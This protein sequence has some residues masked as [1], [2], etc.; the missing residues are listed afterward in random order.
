MKI[1]VLLENTCGREGCTA[2]HGL[3]FY[4]ETETHRLL[5]D[6]GPDDT[7]LDNAQVLGIDLQ[8]I[9]MVII[10]HGHYDHAGGVL[11]FAKVNPQVEIIMQESAVL[12]HYNGSRYIGIDPEIANLSQ[13]KLISGNKRIDD[14]LFL[15]SGVTG[16]RDFPAG[17][18]TMRT[19][20]DGRSIPDDFSHEQHLVIS[21]AGRQI[22]LSGCAHSGI[23]NILDRYKEIFGN[24]PDVV[25]SGFHMMK[26]G[27]PY[28]EEDISIIENTAKELAKTDTVFYTGHCTSRPAFEIMQKIMGEQ[29]K[30]INTGMV[31]NFWV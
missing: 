28:T 31:F 11:P 4:I 25:M 7:L 20:R 6:T 30:E 2:K 3:S 8:K 17:N 19:V 9:E 23:L 27:E 29:I 1:T 13:L 10:S 21:C 5:M 14:E 16:R 18:L 12:P 22:L 15:F 26:P 24:L